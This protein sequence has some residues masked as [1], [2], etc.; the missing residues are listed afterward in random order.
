[1][2][3]GDVT[4]RNAQAVE[5]VGKTVLAARTA[6][7][8]TRRQLAEAADVDYDTVAKLERADRGVGLATLGRLASALGMPV[9]EL[10]R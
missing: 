9:A 3:P 1:M 4:K 6:K 8:L 2:A 7:G 5:K 10:L